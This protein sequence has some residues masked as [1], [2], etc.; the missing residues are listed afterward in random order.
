MG[1]GIGMISCPWLP[2]TIVEL[3]RS[4]GPGLVV[5]ETIRDTAS[6][7]GMTEQ[8]VEIANEAF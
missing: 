5:I 7:P 1:G 3:R 6:A 4:A 2:V 8:Q